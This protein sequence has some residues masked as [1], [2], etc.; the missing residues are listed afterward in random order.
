[1]K[2]IVSSMTHIFSCCVKRRATE[3]V[4]TLR[5]AVLAPLE[6][7][8]ERHTWDHRSVPVDVCEGERCT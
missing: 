7:G 1:M 5:C 8:K 3:Q 2:P 4:S 6:G